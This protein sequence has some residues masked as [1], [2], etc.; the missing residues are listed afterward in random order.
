MADRIK[1]K[2]IKSTGELTESQGR[3]RAELK[4]RVGILY[5]KTNTRDATALRF[6]KA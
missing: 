5:K 1:A 4:G 2:P 6:R 3:V